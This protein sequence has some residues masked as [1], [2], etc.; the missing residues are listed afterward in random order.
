MANAKIVDI[1]GVQWELKDEVAR[2]EIV[3]LKNEIEK[4]RTIEKWHYDIPIYGGKIV[5]RRQGNVVNVTGINIGRVKAL[6]QD[7]GDINLAILPERFRPSE[8]QFF[9]MRI[10]GSYSTKYGGAI[11]QNG[12]INYYTYEIT[13]YGYFSI[14]Y[15]VD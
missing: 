10:S 6:T 11:Y 15:I 9:M 1:K 2:N 14:S 4:L 12:A 13:D 5:A 7:I 3:T 8:I